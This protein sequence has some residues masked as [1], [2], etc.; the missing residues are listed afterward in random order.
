MRS[1]L[2]TNRDLLCSTGYSIQ[3]FVITYK[4]KESEIEYC[5][6]NSYIYMYIYSVKYYIT[7][8]NILFLINYTSIKN[9]FK[10]SLDHRTWNF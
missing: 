6:S 5:L 7:E 8:T 9:I 1:E 4:G 3:Y 10:R 2:L